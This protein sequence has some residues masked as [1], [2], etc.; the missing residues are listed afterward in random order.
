MVTAC[1]VSIASLAL[2]V[3]GVKAQVYFIHQDMQKLRDRTTAL[4]GW[5]STLEDD[6][7]SM[8]RDLAY[9]YNA[10]NKHAARLEDLENR[11]RRNNVRAIGISEKAEGKNPV[12][13]IEKWL[14]SVFGNDAFSPIFSV[15]RAHRVP[16]S[17]LPPGAPPRPFLFKLLNCK[18][19]DAILF[20]ARTLG[21]ALVMDKS[22]YFLNSL[23]MYRSRG[24]NS[25]MLRKPWIYN[26]ICFIQPGYE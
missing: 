19:R 14:L 18:D 11:L 26:M 23:R 2:D 17:P 7:T 9:T 21:V 24:L 13:L 4:E 25:L 16:G 5:V 10:V 8:Q 1:N 20:S 22:L 12:T 3:K 6:M 15:E